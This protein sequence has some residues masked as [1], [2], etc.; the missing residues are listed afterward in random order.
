VP[1]G[2]PA[3]LP[4][5]MFLGSP[6]ERLGAEFVVASIRRASSTVS[7]ARHADDIRDILCKGGERRWQGNYKRNGKKHA[8]P[9]RREALEE[10]V[11]AG[12]ARGDEEQDARIRELEEK[13]AR[14]RAGL[15]HEKQQAAGDHD[16]EMKCDM[17]PN[18]RESLNAMKRRGSN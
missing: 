12:R 3:P 6:S 13:L 18:P 9:V 8:L 16:E 10:Q 1:S 15:D 7:A 14:V 17:K 2:V 4:E 11:L 5:D